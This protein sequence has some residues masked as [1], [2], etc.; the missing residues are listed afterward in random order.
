MMC[1][2][3]RAENS[4]DQSY[5]GVCGTRLQ[6]GSRDADSAPTTYAGDS[7]ELKTGTTFA[8]RYQVIEE[9]G[10][11]GMGRVYKVLDTEIGERIALKLL[12]P[13]LSAD[14]DTL[15]RFSTE[16]KL[17]R[18]ITHRNVCRLYDLG[19]SGSLSYLTM[20]YVAG[21]DLRRLMRKVGIFGAG[22]VV[23]VA[24]QIC[25]GLAEAHRLGIVHR[26]LKPQNVMVDEDGN[27]K[28]MDFGIARLVRGKGITGAGVVVGTPQ[29]M[30][31]EQ[32]DGQEVDQRSDIYSLGVILY[33]MAT[34]RVPFDEDAQPATADGLVRPHREVPGERPG[35]A[36]PERR[37]GPDRPRPNRAGAADHRAG[38]GKE[39]RHVYA[40]HDSAGPAA[41]AGSVRGAGHRRGGTLHLASLVAEGAGFAE[42][43]QAARGGHLVRQPVGAPRPRR[44]GRQS[45]DD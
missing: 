33:E 3:C 9:L 14:R 20:E 16:L 44:R 45:A 2:S 39:A 7:A 13:E 42:V 22:H 40:V 23:R 24:R 12:K 11:G 18:R 35:S 34:G 4:S 37:R 30:S 10:R 38:G 28:I 1:P 6:T 21:E 36:I 26:D 17:A 25:E 15:E 5:C 41:A 31:P 8:N 32:V 43:W 19:R 27:A 29:Y